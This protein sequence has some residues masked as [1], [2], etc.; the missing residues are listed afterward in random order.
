MPSIDDTMAELN[1]DELQIEESPTPVRTRKPRS[2]AGQSRTGRVGRTALAEQLLVPWA[3]L[4]AAVSQPLP[5][6]GAVLL[7]R[8]EATTKALVDLAKGHPKML[9]ALNKAAKA[10]PAS[11]LIQTGALLVMAVAIET[12]RIPADMPL[13]QRAGLDGQS[14]T[15]VYY[16]L[17]PDRMPVPEDIPYTAPSPFGGVPGVPV[18]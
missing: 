7:V 6:V 8:G 12:G 9:A 17:H 13:A 14:M 15:D 3:G 5:L 18:G 10:G 2:D 11:E 16:S 1:F 4:A